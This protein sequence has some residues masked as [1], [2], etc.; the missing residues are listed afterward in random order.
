MYL[1][2]TSESDGRVGMFFG[3]VVVGVDGGVALA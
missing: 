1:T 3:L 2:R